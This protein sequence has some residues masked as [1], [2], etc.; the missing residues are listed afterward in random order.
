MTEKKNSVLKKL[1]GNNFKTRELIE[2]QDNAVVS[3]TLID[4]EAGTIT[5]FAFDKEQSLSEHT[6]PFEALAQILD[7]KCKIKIEDEEIEISEGEALIIPEDRPHSVIAVERFKMLLTM[8]K[9]D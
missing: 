2:Y 9:S 6:A 3:K 4:K 5:I 7:G 1:V 8:I